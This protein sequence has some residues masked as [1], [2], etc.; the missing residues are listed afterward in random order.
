MSMEKF[1]GLTPEQQEIVLKVSDEAVAYERERCSEYEA[2]ALENIK[3]T[4]EYGELSPEAVEEFKAACADLKDLAYKK[5]KDPSVVDL[6]YSEVEKAKAKTTPSIETVPVCK[7]SAAAPTPVPTAICVAVL[8]K[9]TKL[10]IFAVTLPPVNAFTKFFTI[11]A[12]ST[13]FAPIRAD[14]MPNSGG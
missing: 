5:V 14:R 1:E 12:L 6:L 13:V 7:Y 10:D 2:V 8:P 4:M 11:S 3:N 9:R